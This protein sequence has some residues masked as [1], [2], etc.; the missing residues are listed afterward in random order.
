MLYTPCKIPVEL[1]SLV[2][3]IA[4]MDADF[5]LSGIPSVYHYPCSPQARLCFYTHGCLVKAQHD[6]SEKGVDLVPSFVVGPQLKGVTFDFGPYFRSVVVLFQAGAL[7]RLTGIPGAEIVDK[8]LPAE[9][10]F[11]SSLRVLEQQL[12]AL[13]DPEAMG[14]YIA[15][16]L[17]QR[18]VQVKENLPFDHAINLLVRSF[19]NLAIARVADYACLS[20]RQLERKCIERLGMGPK[21][22]ARLVRFSKAYQLKESNPTS[23]W[24]HIAYDLGYHDQMHLIRDFK[25]F[26]GFAPS[27]VVKTFQTSFQLVNMLEGGKG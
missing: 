16:Y 4:V 26:A 14:R 17:L 11:G 15:N 19:G 23:S 24:T 2:N 13:H 18:L 20:L 1:R 22:F 7:Y 9:F 6:G 27:Q 3:S 12:K 21:L 25:T 8:T 10:V 5:A